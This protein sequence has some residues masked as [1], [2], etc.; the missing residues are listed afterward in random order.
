MSTNVAVQPILLTKLHPPSL[1]AGTVARPALLARLHAGLRT[2]LTLIAAPA[3][4]GKTA[5]L[6]A[7]HGASLSTGTPFAWLELD[8]A[9][10]DPV[11]YWRYVITALDSLLPGAG[12]AALNLLASREVIPHAYIL[13][14]LI[15]PLVALARDA[16]LILDDYH[17]ISNAAI[18]EGMVYL[19]DH[20]PPR[21]HLAIASRADPPLPLARLRARG[22]LT[23]IRARDLRFTPDEAGK[24]LGEAGD[25][26]L[27][28]QAVAAL[29]ERTEGWAAGLHLAAL[30]LRDR[31]D[32]ERD[33]FIA[34]FAG[35]ERYVADYL[36]AEVLDRQPS[37]T[38]RFLLSTAICD[39]L[40][41]DLCDTLVPPGDGYTD[42]Q[43]TLEGL[44]RAGLFVI[45]LDGERRWY[46]YHQ[47]F[48]DLL[49]H[50]TRRDDL[51]AL[52]R[53]AGE[54]FATQGMD[55]EAI[56]HFLTA[57]ELERA[58]E[59]IEAIAPTATAWNEHA[60]V[61]RWLAA[62][63]KALIDVRPGLGLATA[64]QLALAGRVSELIARLPIIEAAL[65]AAKYE[66]EIAA[67]RGLTL[68]LYDIPASI[69]ELQRALTLL[70]AGHA[71]L[72]AIVALSLG[73]AY[74]FAGDVVR[75]DEVLSLAIA[76]SERTGDRVTGSNAW[77][78]LGLIRELQG[79][80]TEAYRCHE[81]ALALV[82][83][84]DGVPL[85]TVAAARA[86]IHL[87]IA[88]WEQGN[89]ATAE[90][91]LTTGLEIARQWPGID[92]LWPGAIS[93][94]RLRRAQG[95]ASAVLANL[96][97]ETRELGVLSQ[98]PY[99]RI[100]IGLGLS[101]YSLAEGDTVG[102]REALATFVLPHPIETLPLALRDY[103][104]RTL[105]RLRLAEGFPG[106]AITLLEPLVT[107]AGAGGRQVVV[108]EA[109]A[110]L[111]LARVASGGAEQRRMALAD[112]AGALTIA[113]PDRYIRLFA[114]F[115][116]R[117]V[118]LFSALVAPGGMPNGVGRAE[119]RDY[120]RRLLAAI[121][122]A[123]TGMD[124]AATNGLV[125]P[126]SGRERDVLRL[127]AEGDDNGAIAA[128]LFVATSTVKTHV[129]RIFAKLGVTSRAAAIARARALGLLNE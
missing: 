71:G 101:R 14:A 67:L 86:A 59:L 124:H 38:Q 16:V 100:L 34:R 125:E 83:S 126:L 40:C 12:S 110:A 53:R 10:N 8:E 68:I 78:G 116:P 119:L 106:E 123:Q 56:G 74:W 102:A 93:L 87:G 15:N 57:G 65:G 82:S 28:R 94:A 50:R 97:A 21:L 4:S 114:D 128:R 89:A 122:P 76:L 13:D 31:P 62:L 32:D 104:Q 66:G 45:P 95:A 129:N 1:R 39:R 85:P 121:G 120:A 27:D 19:I 2:K 9:D 73:N 79:R 49:R 115:G 61:A 105:A 42:G 52:H 69:A 63:P 5:L 118:P 112:L 91:H 48:A 72:R 26:P 37:A 35:S 117:L 41:G 3:G 96:V 55:D 127:I 103:Q 54:W 84:P 23:E 33:R 47:L 20:L 99:T 58:S 64:W 25:A 88:A 51:A 108:I 6:S 77:W 109:L 90:H 11:R 70:P 44:E 46:R 17:A 24:L 92:L 111:A 107:T 60:T 80:L 18:Q 22:E 36:I 29:V 113:L 98:Q 81:R 75:G 30:A 43:A 7:W